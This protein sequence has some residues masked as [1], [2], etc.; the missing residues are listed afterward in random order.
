M[1]AWDPSGL[2][3]VAPFKLRVGTETISDI[4]RYDRAS[5]RYLGIVEVATEALETASLTEVTLQDY[6]GNKEVIR[7]E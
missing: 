2:A 1:E 3:K 4:L 6:V 7:V 5:R